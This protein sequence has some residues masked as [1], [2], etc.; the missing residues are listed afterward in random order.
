MDK[1]KLYSSNRFKDI[2]NSFNFIHHVNVP[3]HIQGHTLDII[4]TLEGGVHVSNVE[5]NAFD[6][7]HHSLVNFTIEIVPEIK[8]EK[9]ITYRNTKC[10]DSEKFVSDLSNQINISESVSFGENITAYNVLK[11][12]LN[13]H[14]PIKSRMIKTVQNSPWFDSEYVNLRRLRRKAEEYRKTG[15]IVHKE[16]FVKFRN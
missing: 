5:A 13:V 4:A 7:S 16:I 12:I 14:A 6:I 2:L 10:I 9:V 8:Q 15:L 11:D 1:D 3:T